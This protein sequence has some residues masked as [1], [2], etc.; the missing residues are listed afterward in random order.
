MPNWLTPFIHSAWL[1]AILFA[2][3][4][5]DAFIGTSLFV[6]GEI[7]FVAG[8]YAFAVTHDW[9]VIPLIWLGAL[10]GDLISY[11]VGTRYGETIIRRFVGKGR[12]RRLHYHKARLIML[13]KG[14]AAILTARLTGP[15]A[16]LMPLLAGSMR[17]PFNTVLVASTLGVVFGT[18][19]SLLIGYFLAHGIN[20]WDEIWLFL[21]GL[22]P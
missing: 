19:Q 20:Y 18:L 17:V 15:A 14:G 7:F 6:L 22:L 1:P 21:K 12:K 13:K 5:G 4:F 9:T 3:A 11:A 2:G 10:F 16:K 8:G